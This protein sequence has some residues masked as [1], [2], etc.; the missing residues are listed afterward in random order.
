MLTLWPNVYISFSGL[1][2]EDCVASL[3]ER[4]DLD[5]MFYDS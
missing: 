4:L 5:Q 3:L 1:G 2:E